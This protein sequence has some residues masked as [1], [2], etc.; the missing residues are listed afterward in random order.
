MERPRSQVLATLLIALISHFEREAGFRVVVAKGRGRRGTRKDKRT[1][2]TLPIGALT[3]VY[4]FQYVFEKTKIGVTRETNGWP[5]QLQQ[6]RYQAMGITL[7]DELL[8]E[9]FSRLLERPS[10]ETVS[11]L[12]A[13]LAIL[14][15]FLRAGG[16]IASDTIVVSL[17]LLP[18]REGGSLDLR[19]YKVIVTLR[20]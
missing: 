4:V 13:V 11:D 2:P 18:G 16:K 1:W 7:M 10:R 19:D 5:R 15:A 14:K 9:V 6:I 17:A 20:H 8:V 3:S 12:N